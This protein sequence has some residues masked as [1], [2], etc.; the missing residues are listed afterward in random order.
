MDP[1]IIELE[2]TVAFQSER[3][4]KLENIVSHQQLELHQLAEG[5][6]RMRKHLVDVAPSL[7]GDVDD[8]PPPPHY[9]R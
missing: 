7:V 2:T 8:E 9:G 4:N 5:I 6:E 3:I 1:R